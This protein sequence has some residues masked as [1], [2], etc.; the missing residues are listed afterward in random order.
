L[1][2]DQIVKEQNSILKIIIIPGEIYYVKCPAGRYDRAK[3]KPA[4]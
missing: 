3:G 4:I 1:A 2:T